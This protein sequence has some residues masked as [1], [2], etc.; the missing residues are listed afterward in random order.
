[1]KCGVEDFE[2]LLIDPC[3]WFGVFGLVFWKFC[4]V[5]NHT[6]DCNQHCIVNGVILLLHVVKR[7]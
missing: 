6:V 1:M 7:Y 2:L 3:L 4:Y 5:L